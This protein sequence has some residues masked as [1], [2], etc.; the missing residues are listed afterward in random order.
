MADGGDEEAYY[1]EEE[2]DD[3]YFEDEGAVDH[4]EGADDAL[5]NYSDDET[6]DAL[7]GELPP[8]ALEDSSLADAFATVAQFK[9][10]GKGSGKKPIQSA[11]IPFRASGDI[12]FEQK[13]KE[14]RKSAVK[15][16]K[17]VTFCTACEKK[18]HWA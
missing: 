13:A 4:A 6:L 15:F 2:D 5:V 17:A 12:T 16:L 3:A 10:K 8:D 9:Q 11:G 18:G 7:L 14:Q 1:E